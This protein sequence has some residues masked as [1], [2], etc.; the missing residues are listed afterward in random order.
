MTSNT[1]PKEAIAEIVKQFETFI[2]NDTAGENEAQQYLEENSELIPTPIL[3]G[4][5][6]HDNVIISKF[7][8]KDDLITDFAYI[9]K[10]SAHWE[11]IF[12]E[13]ENPQYKIFTKDKENITFSSRFNHGI[14]Q[15]TTWKANIDGNKSE[16]I[17]KLRPLLGDGK[18][19]WNPKDFKY[20]FVFGRGNQ[21]ESARHKEIYRQKEKDS[22]I[23]FLTY[24]SIGTHLKYKGSIR[25]RI[26]LKQWREGFEIKNDDFDLDDVPLFSHISNSYLKISP[27][28]RVKLISHGY[29]M[30][31][32]DKGQLL[33]FNHK[34]SSAEQLHQF[35]DSKKH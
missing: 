8:I 6:L 22:G 31:D 26:I 14:D 28:L 17:K 10:N 1:K 5:Q 35:R 19:S 24:D 27:A 18:I 13:L 3:L 15:I 23:T 7:K 20:V 21:L 11:I 25:K 9:T 30:D 29:M 4:H 16:V 33:V 2:K 34:Y 32:W 12:I